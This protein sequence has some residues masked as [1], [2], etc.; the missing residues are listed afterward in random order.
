M[1]TDSINYGKLHPG[2]IV[3][4]SVLASVHL[5]DPTYPL[6]EALPRV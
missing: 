2:N 1:Q 4:S 3:E 6:R 5:P